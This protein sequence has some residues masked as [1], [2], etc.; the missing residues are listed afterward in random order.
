MSVFVKNR[1]FCIISKNPSEIMEHFN[2]RGYAVISAQ[3]KNRSDFD[4]YIRLSNYLRNIK[5][6][7]CS[8]SDK[9]NTLCQELECKMYS[10]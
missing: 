9:V 4:K 5:F 3:P 10:H 8:Y 6:L 1:Y 2:F 7:G